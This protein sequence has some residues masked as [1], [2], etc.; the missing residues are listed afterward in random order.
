MENNT[1]KLNSEERHNIELMYDEPKTGTNTYGAYYLYGVKKNKQD[2]SFFATPNLHKQLSSWG[3]GSKLTIIR[4]EY[5]PN[6]FGYKLEVVNGKRKGTTSPAPQ[7]SSNSSI[8]NR[9]HDIHK[10]VCLKL[11][12]DL[13]GE[14]KG[15]ITDAQL[16]MVDANMNHLLNVLENTSS[17]KVDAESIVVDSNSEEDFPF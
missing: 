5:A 13:L 16:I 9:T 8:D 4:D 17:Q 14:V 2:A 6:K 10:Q 15:V 3:T 12:V 1:F 7:A 11:A